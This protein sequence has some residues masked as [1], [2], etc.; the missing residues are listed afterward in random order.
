MGVIQAESGSKIELQ[1]QNG[2]EMEGQ[3]GDEMEGQVLKQG[4]Q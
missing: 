2:D 4:R 1:G 3:N